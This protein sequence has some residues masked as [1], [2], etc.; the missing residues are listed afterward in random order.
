MRENE[1]IHGIEIFGFELK[2]S[3]FADDVSYLIKDFES[4]GHL[5]R[6]FDTFAQF[7]SLKLNCEKSELC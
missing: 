5:C 2:I 3:T 1:N 7:S 4:A 6:L